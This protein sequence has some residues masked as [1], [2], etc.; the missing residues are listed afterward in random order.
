MRVRGEAGPVDGAAGVALFMKGCAASDEMACFN[1]G[2]AYAE[3]K[4]VAVD[5]TLAAETFVKACE[6]GEARGCVRAADI[7]AATGD[8]AA[9]ALVRKLREVGCAGGETAACLTP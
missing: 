7:L 4:G 9:A 3:G 6:L 2:I 1:S 5:R 8:P